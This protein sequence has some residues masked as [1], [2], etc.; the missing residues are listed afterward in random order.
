MKWISV[1]QAIPEELEDV[2]IFDQFEGI[3]IAY[4]F[5]VTN[6]YIVRIDGS[7]LTN[8]GYWMPLPQSPVAEGPL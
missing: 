4:Y 7:R 5:K 1:N 3:N 6:S 2:L 8:V